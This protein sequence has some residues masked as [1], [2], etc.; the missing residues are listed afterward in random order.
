MAVG[1]VALLTR[2][3]NTMLPEQ[4]RL[5]LTAYVDGETSARQQRQ[6]YKLLRRSGE[7][8][9][10]LRQLK[11]DG[12]ALHE[13]PRVS[14]HPALADLVLQAIQARRLKPRPRPVPVRAYL[15]VWAG[16]AAA[17]AV[18]LVV[19]S[20]SYVFF[21]RTLDQP[22]NGNFATNGSPKN[23][24]KAGDAVD[25][26]EVVVKDGSAAGGP[27]QLS[28]MPVRE[29]PG[30]T[31]PIV[32]VPSVEDT[33]PF[34]PD[35]PPEKP[36]DPSVV[37]AP[38]EMV[39]L[40]MVDIAA[41]VIVKL[42]EIDQANGKSFREELPKANGFRIEFPCRSGSRAFE[43]FAA[44][45]K[46]QDVALTVDQ[47]ATDRLK[48]PHLRANYAI[49][50]DDVTPEE[51]T[52]LLQQLAGEDKKAEAKKPV[53]SQFDRVVLVRLNRRDRKELTELLGTDPTV[54][55]S[56]TGPLG[57]DLHKPLSDQT[58]SQIAATLAGQGGTPPRPDG[59]KPVGKGSDHLALA[60]PYTPLRP[61]ANSA[62]VKRY[63]DNRK[64]ARVG[65]LQIFLV[66]R[67]TGA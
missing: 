36:R 21:S 67:E 31:T 25:L 66:I 17:A 44:A 37:T 7:A 19:C 5:L 28:V 64:P 14:A 18:L 46:A 34:D 63:F 61:A 57:T 23:P 51:L 13:L 50:L 45:C 10:L 29:Q 3:R 27:E 58:G 11:V 59:T 43:R 9:E 53:E 33:N 38:V 55:A 8:R 26:I 35:L 1:T 22:T 20:A 42:Q 56:A 39:Q 16:Y 41:P 40:Q 54:K 12:L 65:T 32:Q 60:V 24:N 2:N 6:L 48:H 30:E 62:E 52:R 49:Y 4:D 15:T 47:S